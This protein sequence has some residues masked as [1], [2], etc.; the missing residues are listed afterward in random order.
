MKTWKMIAVLGLCA[1]LS[2]ACDKK[3]ETPVTDDTVK[4]GDAPDT[5]ADVKEEPPAE[6]SAVTI[7]DFS[8]KLADSSCEWVQTCK[9]EEL[10]QYLHFGAGM[11]ISFGAMGRPDLAA[12]IEPVMGILKK[13]KEEKTLR[14]SLEDCKTTMSLGFKLG[15]IDG[16]SL[17]TSVDAGRV[18]FNEESATACINGFSEEKTMCAE[19]TKVDPEAKMGFAQMQAT[20]QKFKGGMDPLTKACDSVFVGLVEEGGECLESYECKG[21]SKCLTAE[22]EKPGPDTKKACKPSPPKDEEPAP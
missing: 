16:A 12:D 9:N 11:M 14:L 17:K 3:T 4:D 7:E 15:R 19:E 21:E 18:E 8:T 1:T 10:V 5:A 20:E 2:T 13:S 6:P 22:G